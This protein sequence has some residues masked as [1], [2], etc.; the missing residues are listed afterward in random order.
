MFSFGKGLK[1]DDIIT[2]CK[3]K[4]LNVITKYTYVNR[5]PPK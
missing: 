2:T 1:N 5:A 4:L 3:W